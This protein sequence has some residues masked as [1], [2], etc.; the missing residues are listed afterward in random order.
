MMKNTMIIIILLLLFYSSTFA[1]EI[2]EEFIFNELKELDGFRGIK[3]GTPIGEVNGLKPVYND[4]RCFRYIMINDVMSIGN[5]KL[6]KI[7]YDFRQG[8]FSGVTIVCRSIEDRKI[9]KQSF[10]DLFGEPTFTNSIVKGAPHKSLKY[11]SWDWK[12]VSL[13]IYLDTNFFYYC[14]IIY[15]PK[16]PTSYD[17]R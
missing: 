4:K 8:I 9:L 16:V 10:T 13:H 15:I 6:K 3:F 7:E 1:K 14:R 11:Y 2:K 12:S 17:K 5:A